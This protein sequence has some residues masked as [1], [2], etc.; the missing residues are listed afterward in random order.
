MDLGHFDWLQRRCSMLCSRREDA[1]ELVRD[2]K[3]QRKQEGEGTKIEGVSDPRFFI[4]AVCIKAI[5]EE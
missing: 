3:E 4:L 5:G 2:S 1:P